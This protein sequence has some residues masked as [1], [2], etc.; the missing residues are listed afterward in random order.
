MEQREF[1]QKLGGEI[2]LEELIK[3]AGSQLQVDDLKS[4]YDMLTNPQ[5]MGSRFKFFAMFPAIVKEHLQ[6]FPVNGFH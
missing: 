3:N 5:Q 2:R 1:L 4:S 6:K